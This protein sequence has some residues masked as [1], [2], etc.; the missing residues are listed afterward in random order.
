MYQTKTS[1][2]GTPLEICLK[3]AAKSGVKMLQSGN[4]YMQPNIQYTNT[5]THNFS[6][7]CMQYQPKCNIQHPHFLSVSLIQTC[8]RTYTHAQTF[9]LF[10]S[11]NHKPTFW[12]WWKTQR[13][14]WRPELPMVAHT[15]NASKLS[16]HT[17]YLLTCHVRVTVGDSGLCCVCVMPFQH[18]LTPLF[19]D[20]AQALWA[21]FCFR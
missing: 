14:K 19:I 1:T 17:L 10:L 6:H 2:N 15:Q 11:L 12:S 16:L 7:E 4:W 21:F 9:S 8:M 5:N 3:D 20:S 13:Q 18:Y